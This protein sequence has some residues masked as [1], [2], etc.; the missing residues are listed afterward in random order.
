MGDD[1]TTSLFDYYSRWVESK[2]LIART[3]KSVITASKELFATYGI[4]DIVIS[5]HGPCLVP[6]P[7]KSVLPVRG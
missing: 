1:Y 5:D 4:A 3:A 7:S 6:N 2:L